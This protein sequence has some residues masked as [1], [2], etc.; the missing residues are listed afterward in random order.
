MRDD[1]RVSP[2]R[3]PETASLARDHLANERTYLAWLRTAAAVMAL[4]LAVASFAAHVR[5]L[6]A[7]AGGLLVAT[8]GAGVVYGTAR[9]RRVTRDLDAGRF[10]A[11][12][13]GRAAVIASTVLVLAVVAA[14]VLL[15]VGQY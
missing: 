10:A 14:L 6:S 4:G 7:V 9:Y 5:V 12:S 2:D 3:P 13:H 15:I 1:G 8:G 11:G